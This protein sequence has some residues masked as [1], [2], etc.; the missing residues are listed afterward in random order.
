MGACQLKWINDD[1]A[2]FVRLRV[3]A[4]TR[5]MAVLM[6]RV[7]VGTSGD[8]LASPWRLGSWCSASC[9]SVLRSLGE[10][11]FD[12]TSPPPGGLPEHLSARIFGAAPCSLHGPVAVWNR[13]VCFLV[14]CVS[15][16]NTPTMRVGLFYLIFPVPEGSLH[17][18]FAHYI[19]IKWRGS[20][21][22]YLATAFFSSYK[23]WSC[24]KI[25]PVESP[26]VKSGSD[27]PS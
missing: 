27:A 7:L 19:I 2:H 10:Q 17:R 14:N 21:L 26:K 24:R 8:L 15:F 18:V 11:R 3:L 20:Q 23:P 5:W 16:L 4:L 9:M 12:H 13:A 6:P 1:S 25:S 22:P